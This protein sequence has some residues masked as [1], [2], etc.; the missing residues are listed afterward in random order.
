MF[1]TETI[2]FKLMRIL[3]CLQP[4]LIAWVALPD[5][6]V[7]HICI[8]QPMPLPTLFKAHTAGFQKPKNR[9]PFHTPKF[10]ALPTSDDMGLARLKEKRSHRSCSANNFGDSTQ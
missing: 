1:F 4:S 7:C 9:L 2:N 6:K 3:V 10:D 8:K 5:D